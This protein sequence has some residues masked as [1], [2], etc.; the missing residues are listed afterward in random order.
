MKKRRKTT[1]RKNLTV[2]EKRVMQRN[3]R[4][5][6]AVLSGIL[7]LLIILKVTNLLPIKLQQK[8]Q[9]SKWNFWM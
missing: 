4:I 5:G 6:V 3:R 1:K 8:N 7:F 2:K 9:T